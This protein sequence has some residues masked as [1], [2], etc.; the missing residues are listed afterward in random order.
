MAWGWISIQ[1]FTVCQ[2]KGLQAALQ[3][4]LLSSLS[5]Q[6]RKMGCRLWQA[7]PGVLGVLHQGLPV[8]IAAQGLE[9]ADDQQAGARAR[10]AHVQAALV[11]HKADARMLAP[12]LGA[13]HC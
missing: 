7:A 3:V 5:E 4:S 13:A 6:S 9:V 11:C 2:G 12:P 10:E 8:G 1:K